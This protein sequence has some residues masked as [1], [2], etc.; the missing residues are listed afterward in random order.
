MTF[1]IEIKYYI[2]IEFLQGIPHKAASVIAL[3]FIVSSPPP[4]VLAALGGIVIK[5]L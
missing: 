2:Q 5:F 3:G 4:A 1:G